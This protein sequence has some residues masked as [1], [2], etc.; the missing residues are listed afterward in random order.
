MSQPRR[1]R[2]PATQ[3]RALAAALE[4]PAASRRLPRWLDLIFGP[5]SQPGDA[6]EAAEN[7]FHPFTYAGG[8]DLDA[9]DDATLRDAAAAQI[10]HFGQ[11]PPRLYDKQHPPRRATSSSSGLFDEDDAT[12]VARTA[13]GAATPPLSRAS[14]ETDEFVELDIDGDTSAAPP[15]P[16]VPTAALGPVSAV[17]AAGAHRAFCSHADGTVATFSWAG[18]SLRLEMFEALHPAPGALQPW[19]A[20]YA[21]ALATPGNADGEKRAVTPSP[22]VA[23]VCRADPPKT[24]RG[25]A[26]AATWIFRRDESHAS[27]MRVAK[28]RHICKRRPTAA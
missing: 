10:A 13:Y 21:V 9:V 26:A 23:Y 6:A 28:A 12:F 15:P 27:G 11:T 24:H 19:G 2:N 14:S 18:G 17:L 20:T 1:R 5:A 7:V 3:V 16:P 25:D 8:A 22:H 4:S